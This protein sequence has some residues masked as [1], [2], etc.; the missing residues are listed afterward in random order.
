M[1]G[2][3]RRELR[4][5]LLD[6]AAQPS[7]VDGD[8]RAAVLDAEERLGRVPGARRSSSSGT[9]RARRRRL[10]KPGRRP[11]RRSLS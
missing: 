10:P 4:R 9:R 11:R 6:V 7:G 5:E 1:G 2:V 3:A 8:R